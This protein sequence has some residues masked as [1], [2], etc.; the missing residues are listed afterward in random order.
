MKIVRPFDIVGLTLVSPTLTSSNVTSP[1]TGTVSYS[2][3]TAYAL[4]DKVTNN[5][6]SL[7]VTITVASPAVITWT[8]HELVVGDKV[9]FTTTSALPTGLTA[10]YLYYVQEILTANTF[11]VSLTNGGPAVNTRAAGAGVHTGFVFDYRVYKSLQAANTNHQPRLASSSAWWQAIASTNR[12]KMFDG[13]VTSQ[14]KFSSIDITIAVD[15]AVDTIALLNVSGVYCSVVCTDTVNGVVYNVL[16]DLQVSG[17]S[18]AEYATEILIAGI[19]GFNAGTITIIVTKG[20]FPP[21]LCAIGA[22]LIGKAVDAGGTEYGATVGIQDFSI[23]EAND[24][25]DYDITVRAFSKRASFQV[26]VPAAD[27]P[28][29]YRILSELRAQK[30]LYVGSD[31]YTSTAIYGYPDDWSIII[32]YPTYSILNI[33]IKGLT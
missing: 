5:T 31:I 33:D 15:K 19:T 8:A 9:S 25:G 11:T 20:A 18:P 17:A 1:E 14:T 28:R 21:S 32:Q 3:A 26:M 24:F 4:N 16:H 2:S 27:V 13:S 10:S 12:W 29:I 23:V 7:V 6:D 22:C 30:C